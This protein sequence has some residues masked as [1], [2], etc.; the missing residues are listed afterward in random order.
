MK[1][2]IHPKYYPDAKVICAC[3]N[4]WTTGSTKA[5]IRTE[6]CSKCHPFFTGEQ[7]IVDTAGQVERFE[8]RRKIGED[9]QVE[10]S[11]RAPGKR[12]EN[13]FEFVTDEPAAVVP[14]TTVE[15]AEEAPEAFASSIGTIAEAKL[16]Q[17]RPKKQQA[18]AATAPKGKAAEPKAPRQPKKAKEAPA[19]P[20]TAGEGPAE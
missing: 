11:T 8:R 19:V 3:G 9:R 12:T 10:M 17:R 5:E 6:M 13:L 14:S 4:T 16:Q 15:G 1:K 18:P 7:R 2:D 20:E